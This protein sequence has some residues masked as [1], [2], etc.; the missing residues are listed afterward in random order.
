[1][2]LS[3]RCPIRIWPTTPEELKSERTTVAERGEDI[4]AVKMAIYR[5]TG[6]Y[7]IACMKA[8]A[9]YREKRC[10]LLLEKYR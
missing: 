6:K 2:N 1:M 7:D 4:V 9:D 10:N 5:E 8:V 3:L